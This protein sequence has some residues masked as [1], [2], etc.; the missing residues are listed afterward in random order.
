[1][2]RTFLL[3]VLAFVALLICLPLLPVL[4]LIFTLVF[5]EIVIVAVNVIL[6]TTLMS[7]SLAIA[8]ESAE[9]VD[10]SVLKRRCPNLVFRLISAADSRTSNATALMGSSSTPKRS[11]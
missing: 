9:N 10:T 11:R 2:I 6:L 4:L 3:G 5:P 1:M 7:A 8:L